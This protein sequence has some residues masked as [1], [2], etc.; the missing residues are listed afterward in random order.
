MTQT[1]SL[2]TFTPRTLP[3]TSPTTSLSRTASAFSPRVPTSKNSSS[4]AAISA[5]P[6]HLLPWLAASR[7]SAPR[8]SPRRQLKSSPPQ[9]HLHAAPPCSTTSSSRCEF[10]S[11]ASSGCFGQRRVSRPHQRTR[12]LQKSTLLGPSRLETRLSP[13]RSSTSTSTTYRWR[14]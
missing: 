9:H 6:S 13:S 4:L 3:R 2:P 5:S 7:C 8:T 12:W 1:L 10:P 14:T 11:S